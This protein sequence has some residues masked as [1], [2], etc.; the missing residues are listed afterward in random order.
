MTVLK[1][2]T[3]FYFRLYVLMLCRTLDPITMRKIRF[4]LEIFLCIFGI[5]CC[6]LLVCLPEYAFLSYVTFGSECG[7]SVSEAEHWNLFELKK[8]YS[9]DSNSVMG[10]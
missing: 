1:T 3:Q 5:F 8:F 6:S 9:G 2:S 7:N 10:Y 4:L